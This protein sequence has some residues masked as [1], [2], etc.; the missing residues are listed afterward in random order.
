MSAIAETKVTS[1]ASARA[2]ATSEQR[3]SLKFVMVLDTVGTKLMKIPLTVERV[4][5]VH[6]LSAEG[7]KV[8]LFEA[9]RLLTF[10]NLTVQHFAFHLRWFV[11][12]VLIA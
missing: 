7:E 4:A 2:L 6:R 1:R 3:I 12:N 8:L 9:L 11:I 5:R 10:C